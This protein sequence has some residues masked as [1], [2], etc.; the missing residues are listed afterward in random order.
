MA[1]TMAETKRW[2]AE[3]WVW[4]L[5]ALPMSAVVGGMITIY[6]AVT[7]SDGLVVDD[8]YNRSKAINM[9]LARDRAAAS[10][11]LRARID[12]DRDN[13]RILLSLDSRDNLQPAQ[14]RFSLL[15]PTRPGNDQI[16]LLQSV[17]E[18][19]YAGVLQKPLHDGNWYVQLEA[20]DWRLSGSL[21]TPRD[22]MVVLA[23]ATA[24][25]VP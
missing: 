20:D 8:Y 22:S 25:A 1:V 6:L 9:D 13:R 14:V 23:P 4:L 11:E 18:G 21:R 24:A 12:L 10:H 5:I 19:V 3:P 15:H 17:G 7:T 16:I 2:Y